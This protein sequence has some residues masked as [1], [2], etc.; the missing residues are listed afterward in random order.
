M[1]GI[2]MKIVSSEMFDHVTQKMKSCVYENVEVGWR[3]F[4]SN[5]HKS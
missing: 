3:N 4:E 2:I 1:H 5:N